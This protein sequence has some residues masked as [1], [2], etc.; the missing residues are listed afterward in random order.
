MS[1]DNTVQQPLRLVLNDYPPWPR[2]G[3]NFPVGDLTNSP[4]TPCP[5][6]ASFSFPVSGPGCVTNLGTTRT[7]LGFP[8]CGPG[9]GLT[10]LAPAPTSIG[11]PM[12]AQVLRSAPTLQ[13]QGHSH[14]W[15]SGVR[16]TLRDSCQMV[17][18]SSCNL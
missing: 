3:L 16:M 12:Q 4:P 6:S 13:P 14:S 17:L 11:F 15:D 8:I 10:S 7:G 18:Q 1:S 5:N 9:P 2:L